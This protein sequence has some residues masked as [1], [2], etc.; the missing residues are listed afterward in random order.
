[1]AIRQGG[2]SITSLTANRLIKNI[3][4]EVLFDYASIS[5]FTTFLTMVK[6]RSKPTAL[7]QFTWEKR[8]G[9]PRH[10]ESESALIGATSIQIIAA[11]WPILRATDILQNKRTGEQVFVTTTPTSALVDVTRGFANTS[12]AAVNDADIWIRLGNAQGEWSTAPSL[13]GTDPTSYSNYV[14]EIRHPF[15]ASDRA[16]AIG[17]A[18]GLIGPT[19]MEWLDEDTFRDHQE[20]K[21]KILLWGR[22]SLNGSRSTTDG[23]IAQITR[24]STPAASYDFTGKLITRKRLD[25]FLYLMF[26]YSPDTK[27]ALTGSELPA[28]VRE[29][30]YGKLWIDEGVNSF[31]LRLNTYKSPHGDV[32]FITHPYFEEYGM[33]G[34]AY[35]FE[36]KCCQLRGI[37]GRMNTVM[38]T[39]PSGNG[40]QAND[41]HGTIFE[42]W[43]EIGLQVSMLER[44]GWLYGMDSTRTAD[45]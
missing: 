16:I 6:G 36:P 23:L 44:C 37:K 38:D 22:Q 25:D 45:A 7:H 11:D 3:D 18:G 1:M 41:V 31:G 30:A 20:A 8:T 28:V 12:A 39:G 9:V 26:K 4:Q 15:G 27:M 29:W 35:F 2:S 13:I 14:Q 5:P 43:A 21:E 34:Y 40:I 24:T 33:S 32:K 19:E 42:Y 10:V 17:K